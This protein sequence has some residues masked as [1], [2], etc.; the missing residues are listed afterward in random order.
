MMFTDVRQVRLVVFSRVPFFIA[1]SATAEHEYA[2][3]RK[4]AAVSANKISA[5]VHVRIS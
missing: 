5:R 3:L 1:H 2:L 4:C